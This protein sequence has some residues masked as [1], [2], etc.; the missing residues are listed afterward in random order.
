MIKQTWLVA[1]SAIALTAFSAHAQIAP[2]P[3]AAETADGR[4]LSY[5]PEFFADS[6]PNTALDMVNRVPGFRLENGDDVRGYAGAGGNALI[7][8]ARPASKSDTA[9]DVLARTP[10]SRVERIELIRGGA[11]GIDMQ[12]RS[13]LVNVILSDEASRQHTV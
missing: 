8:G 2:A 3:E 12:G 11:P 10:A 5:E 7:N 4:I 6:N 1:V 9:S 13:V